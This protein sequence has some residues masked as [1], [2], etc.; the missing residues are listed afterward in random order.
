MAFTGCWWCGPASGPARRSGYYIEVPPV[1]RT[2]SGGRCASLHRLLV[3]A[4]PTSRPARSSPRSPAACVPARPRSRR[5]A[6]RR[7]RR[8][9]AGPPGVARP[10]ASS[11]SSRCSRRGRFDIGRAAGRRRRRPTASACSSRSAAATWRSSTSPPAAARCSRPL[12]AT[13]PPVVDDGR[14]ARRPATRVVDAFDAADGSPLWKRAAAAPAAFAPVARGGWVFVALDDGSSSRCAP[15]PASP[16]GRAPEGHRRRAPVVEGDRALRRGHRR[17]L[18]ALAVTDGSRSGRRRS[19][20]TSTAM[21]AVAGHVFVATGGRWLYALDAR[22]GAGA[23]AL[24]HSGR[25]PSAWPST[26]IAWSR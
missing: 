9:G 18:Q 17:R 8:R 21:A 24:S 16:S 20:A 1:E 7:A 19:T 23:L 5:A 10:A 2:R 3:V 11:P 6:P 14:A 13:L 15:T 25:R 26:R 4:R 12:A 22:K